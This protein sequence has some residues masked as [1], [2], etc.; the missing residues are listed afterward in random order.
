MSYEDVIS[1]V[2]KS[3]LVPHV[4]KTSDGI[5]QYVF[6]QSFNS[7]IEKRT[8]TVSAN[9]PKQEVFEI[10]AKL[11]IQQNFDRLVEYLDEHKSDFPEYIL[12]FLKIDDSNVKPR[13]FGFSPEDKLAISTSRFTHEV[14][15]YNNCLVNI[16]GSLINQNKISYVLFPIK[17]R[18][19]NNIS[20]YVNVV[21][22]IFTN[23]MAILKVKIPF[24][25]KLLDKVRK[26]ELYT[27]FDIY[28][29]DC[30]AI[31]RK[32]EYVKTENK[33]IYKILYSFS[34]ALFGKHIENEMLNT[35]EHIIISDYSPILTSFVDASNI[36]KKQLFH[37]LHSDKHESDQNESDYSDF[38]VSNGFVISGCRYLFDKSG[39]CLS[40]MSSQCELY[41]S[42][43]NYV[44]KDELTSN[45]LENSIDLWIE[46]CVLTRLNSQSVYHFTCDNLNVLQ[47]TKDRYLQNENYLNDIFDM[48]TVQAFEL[49]EKMQLELKKYISF[50]NVNRRWKRIEEIYNIRKESAKIKFN[51]LISV[52]VFIVTVI[53]SLPVVRETVIIFRKAFPQSD[54]P[55][56]TI[57]NVSVI[58]WILIVLILF[59]VLINVYSEYRSKLINKWW[60][61]DIS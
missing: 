4:I 32:Y 39:R 3:D 18:L 45:I 52:S 36:A 53:F 44:N 23:N 56:L 41:D 60:K 2:E 27:V 22:D 6:K 46:I 28:T 30:E 57:D 47:K 37:L 13:G 17:L 8:K 25:G 26:R 42:L 35:F 50:N 14:A 54:I 7:L 15:N 48:T 1:K 16:A 21:I 24:T 5:R 49:F 34:K 9:Q 19:E 59:I 20:I 55:L 58:I 61:H 12:D 43:L 51:F 31:E 10:D 11:S 33:D 40:L 38:W 29:V